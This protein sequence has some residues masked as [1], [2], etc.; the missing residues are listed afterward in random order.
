MSGNQQLADI[1]PLKSLP[2][3]TTLDL[4]FTRVGD[5]SFDTL[6][7]MTGLKKIVLTNS[8]MSEAKK[9]ELDAALT[10]CEVVF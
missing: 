9:R 1:T 5:A 6:K 7:S 2:R 3:L 8:S 4:S 10:N